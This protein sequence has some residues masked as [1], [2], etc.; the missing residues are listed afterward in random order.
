MRHKLLGRSGLRVSE[1][2]LGTL[3]FGEAKAWGADPTAAAC[4][5]ESFAAA[6]GTFIDTAP[7]YASGEAERIV[8]RFVAGR[9]HDFVIATKYTAQQS[10]HPLAGGNSR[11]SL[12]RSVEESLDRLGTDYLDIL[13][14]HYWD[15]TTPMDEVL[16]A[17]DDLVRAG[18]LLYI[19]LSD[20][21]AWL[22]SRAD[23]MAEMR[24]WTRVIATQLEYNVAA[25][26]V[27]RELL[28][29]AEALE[30]GVVAW[31]PLAAG[32]LLGQ[33]ESRRRRVD[34]LPSLLTGAADQ[35]ADLAAQAGLQ[36]IALALRWLMQRPV[37]TS[38]VPVLGARTST[39][40][41]ASIKAAAEALPDDMIEA[42]DRLA[43]P[44]LGFPHD[45]IASSYLRRLATGDPA[46]LSPPTRQ[47]C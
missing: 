43:P 10:A 45:L 17:L 4:I 30:L 24:G 26:A 7:N 27:E 28:P 38:I 42:L 40:I 37:Q 16:R 9:R 44:E 2:C 46:L 32:A 8:G 12:I 15:G 5:L 19:G 25:R 1:L 6:G 39:Q 18:K 20:T 31:G 35:L 29:M 34:A 21:P 13:W 23:L 22:I 41:G 14:L 36:P 11:K 33:P 47:R 3:T